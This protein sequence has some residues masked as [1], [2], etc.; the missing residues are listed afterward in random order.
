M[1]YVWEA[2][3]FRTM[4]RFRVYTSNNQWEKATAA[5]QDWIRLDDPKDA[6]LVGSNNQKGTMW[7][8]HCTGTNVFIGPFPNLTA[9]ADWANKTKRVKPLLA[10]DV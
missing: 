7:V 4:A 3:D 10:A 5:S 1:N 6:E 9:M 8:L 2:E